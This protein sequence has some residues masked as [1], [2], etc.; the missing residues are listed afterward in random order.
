[1]GHTNMQD[2]TVRGL[3]VRK[4]SKVFRYCVVVSSLFVTSMIMDTALTRASAEHQVISGS[5]AG[6]NPQS[7]GETAPSRVVE[8]Y[9]K[10]PLYFI[11]NDGQMDGEV[12]FYEKGSGH[13][14]FFTGRGV[15]LSLSRKQEK[16]TSDRDEEGSKT[17]TAGDTIKPGSPALQERRLAT[18]DKDA[19]SKRER[20]HTVHT[21]H[22]TATPQLVKLVPLGAKKNP[23]IV[24]EGQQECKVNYLIGNDPAKWKTS[25][26]TYQSVV[27]RELYKGIDMKFYG[28]NRQMEYDIIV[29]PGAS[30]SRVQLSYE[31]VEDVRIHENGDMEIVLGSSLKEGAAE[32]SQR[33]LVK[34]R[35]PPESP[36][37]KGEAGVSVE[38]GESRERNERAILQKKPYVY[39]IIDGKKVEIDGKFRVLSSGHGIRNR[40][41][42]TCD[43]LSRA[44]NQTS[45]FIYGFTVA[46]YD[47]RYPL[48]I[49]PTLI[50][51]TYLGGSG[52]DVGFG[53]AVDSAGNAYVTG[54]TLSSDFPTKNAMYGTNTGN[55]DAFVTK[56]DASGTSLSYSTYLGGIGGDWGYGIAVDD[57]GN[58]YI[59]GWT[60]SSDFPME[61][62]MY[63]T[64]TGYYDVFVT[65]LDASGASLSY[66]TYLGGSD[67]DS[68]YSIAV[69]SGGNAYVT[70]Y[71]YSSDFPTVNALY[72]S[73]NGGYNDVFVT[74]LDASG[75]SLSYSTYLGG[76]G[77]DWGYGIAVDDA[78]N[79]YITGW[80]GSSDFPM[81][82][83][84]YGTN[85]GYYDVF[86]TKLDASGASL[87]YST[88]L[89][90]SDNDS[91]YSIAVDSGGN[92]YVTGYT[93]SSDFPTVNA[94]Y[95]SFNGGYNDVFVTKLDAS[96]TS[97][98][99]STY[100]GGS[101][102]D[103]GHSIA[104]D[105]SGNAY[106]TGWTVSSDFPTVNALYGSNT[107]NVDAFVTKIAASGT[108]LSYS[109][110][111]G[112]SN[113]D[114]G[115]SIAVD[116]AGNAYVTGYTWSSDFP[117]KNAFDG[118]FNGG[119]YDVFVTKIDA[120]GASLS[121][122]TYLGG[123]DYDEGHSIAVD[124]SGNAYVTGWTV[125]SDF[126]T[127][128]ALY[129]SNTGNVDAFV[130]KIAA[131]GTSLSYS[132]YLGGSN[133]DGGHS[134]AVDSAGNAYVTGYTWSSDFPTKN[135]FDG[136]FNGGSYDVFVT[137]ID[138]S[139][140]S[141]SYSTYL[142]GSD[143]D[144]GHSI[145]VDSSGNAYVT[146][147]TV[148][149]DFP[150]VNALYGSNTGFYD[151]FVTKI[152]ASGTSLSYSTYLG[153]SDYDVG[154]SIAIDCAGN[155]YVTGETDSSD[156]STKNAMYGTHNGGYTDA[157]VT[158]I[159]ADAMP[160][161]VATPTPS[162]TVTA[163]PG[164]P[165]PTPMVTSTP[166]T[167][168]PTPSPT[169]EPCKPKKLHVS[170]KSLKLARLTSVQKIVT[171]TCKKGLPSANRLVKVK[172][173]SGKKRV[174]VL[175]AMKE[176][177]EHGKAAFTITATEK[178]GNAV[179]RFKYK[180]LTGDVTVKV[181]K[182]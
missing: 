166:G 9:G 102:Y 142:G 115:H 20:P 14:T 149:S 19:A 162:P 164:A 110:Y 160:T 15:T 125:S 156:F 3:H 105:S 134:I 88:Y 52:S 176:T 169:P 174:T 50:Y 29:K 94:L 127:V 7:T 18:D 117:T 67:N 61:N 167:P 32:G 45:S 34:K 148:S 120:S 145:A 22:N 159:G 28:N 119:S 70:G 98:S 130:T 6:S 89:G 140:A 84:M 137:K 12:K 25:I 131:S 54:I 112:G 62:A 171:L 106:V 153:G 33:K 116:S 66:S 82:N 68:G 118:S 114:G 72:G 56:L 10:L 42:E 158:K 150:T 99:Y 182:K 172:I 170:P 128:N 37:A 109:T 35:Q 23:E 58:A 44:N 5:V 40:K 77:G 75:T 135:A 180:N 96:G 51:S 104:V 30:P 161:P 136:S 103:E 123:S 47:K 97:L 152:D 151:A 91:G 113:Y 81:E 76:I 57:A 59:T 138:A 121:Y 63:G 181:K 147:W 132:T 133:Y 122:S 36:F 124:S 39:Q 155:A 92:A 31:G 43:G 24:A 64:N 46:S 146:G 165:T 79:A 11:R 154:N 13:A 108:S 48:V 71:T 143:Y 41:S 100:L 163:T 101:D 144:E 74:K 69:D 178:T 8:T 139:G 111:L 126:P 27:Y 157:F 78:G 80:T 38:T 90:G 55:V 16:E 86:V 141:L 179:V 73:F 83:A 21:T 60:G 1:M 17:V 107:G 93:Y 4:R 87:S 173:V 49:D 85:T 175:P 95:G 168:T 2:N 26:P 65:K 53:I 129:G 177:D